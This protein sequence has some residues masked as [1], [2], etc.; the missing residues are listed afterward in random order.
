MPIGY[1]LLFLFWVTLEIEMWPYFH[2]ELLAVS[3]SAT[4][5]LPLVSSR[6]ILTGLPLKVMS[7]LSNCNVELNNDNREF[8]EPVTKTDLSSDRHIGTFILNIRSG[9]S[10][11]ACNLLC[12][13]YVDLRQLSCDW[14]PN[15]FRLIGFHLWAAQG[16]CRR[17]YRM[18]PSQAANWSI[19]HRLLNVP[20]FA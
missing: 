19:L 1:R 8:V 5:I 9:N 12:T 20:G 15:F 4:K 17:I 10:S 14:L 3:F 18:P 2:E 7:C 16:H 13:L 11:K 6:P